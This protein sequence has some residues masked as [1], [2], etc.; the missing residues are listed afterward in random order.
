MLRNGHNLFHFFLDLGFL[1]VMLCGIYGCEKSLLREHHDPFLKKNK[2]DYE[3]LTKPIR[4]VPPPP[5]LKSTSLSKATN[6]QNWPPSFEKKITV[7]FSEAIPLKDIFE[8]VANQASVNLAFDPIFTKHKGFFYQA[9]QQP[10]KDIVKNICALAGVCYKIQNNTLVIQEDIPFLKTYFV[11]FLTGTRQNQNRISIT[12]DVLNN[13]SE[14]GP[15]S[16]NGSDTLLTSNSVTDFW[17]ELEQALKLMLAHSQE[18]TQKKRAGSSQNP[19]NY[20]LHKQAGMLSVYGTQSQHNLVELY[21]NQLKEQTSTQIVIEAK[22]VEVA[23][24]DKN[25]TGIN[26]SLLGHQAAAFAPMGEFTSHDTPLSDIKPEKN[27]FTIAFKRGDFSAI[28]ELMAQFGTTRTLSNPRMTVLNNQSALFKFAKNEVFFRL[29]VERLIAADGKPDVENTTS[30][31]QTIPIGLVMVVQPSVNLETQEIT[32]TLRPS[33]SKIVATKEDPA[34]TIKSNNEVTSTIPVVQIRE[35]D[36]VLKVRS[37]EVIVMGG[38]MEEV[39]ED[40]ASGLPGLQ[41]IPIFGNMF[42]S[43]E[44]Q[45]EVTELVIFLKASIVQDET[46]QPAD[47]RLYN[48]FTQDPRPLF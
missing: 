6:R 29:D 19:L 27:L 1:F 41:D 20:A 42:Q 21:L 18:A 40:R 11:P 15:A 35:M 28:A 8:A 36:S 46:I 43:R 5:A 34:V 31:V 7:H 4:L 45:R 33:I 14:K 13:T 26:W 32:L 12:T 38:F 44:D 23:L 2:S 25:R 48:Q 22:I 16:D 39:V 47:Y 30:Q 3:Q 17:G 10:I 9:Y 24:S 37:G